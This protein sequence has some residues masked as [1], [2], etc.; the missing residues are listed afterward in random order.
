MINPGRRQNLF[1]N[2]GFLSLPKLF[3]SSKNTNWTTKENK[4]LLEHQQ[5]QAQFI[6]RELNM[7]RFPALIL[8]LSASNQWTC[9]Q[10]LPG[11]GSFYHSALQKAEMSKM[12]NTPVSPAFHRTCLRSF[13]QRSSSSG[14]AAPCSSLLMPQV[15][16][17]CPPTPTS[18]SLVFA[19][20]GTG[21][22]HRGCR[23]RPCS[24]LPRAPRPGLTYI[25]HR[26][27]SSDF[28]GSACM[29]KARTTWPPVRQFI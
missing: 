12:A 5:E 22:G 29:R 27:S 13:A 1:L 25:T 8:L 20:G 24:R 14:S 4:T 26:G 28:K 7:H 2:H 17:A 19:H 15:L 21:Q 16:T 9:F 11:Y 3:I 23:A 10:E 18:P 6:Y